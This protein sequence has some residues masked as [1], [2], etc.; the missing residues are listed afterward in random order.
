MAGTFAIFFFDAVPKVKQDILSKVPI[1]GD[2]YI[3]EI[4]PEDNPF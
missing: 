3:N 2:F 1:I 4:P